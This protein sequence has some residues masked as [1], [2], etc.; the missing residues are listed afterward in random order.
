MNAVQ[1]DSGTT[2]NDVKVTA[3]VVPEHYRLGFLPRHFGRYFG[4]L[5]SA[6]YGHL[7]NLCPSYAGGFWQFLDLSNGGCFMAPSGGAYAIFAPNGFQ[8]TVD[9]EVVGI[10]ATLYALSHLSFEHEAAE[11][12]AERFHQLREF[13]LEHPQAGIIL[14]A[15]D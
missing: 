5:E 4:L 9:G 7:G 10:I 11:V 15:I 14:G 6:V 3:A 2:G 13:A 1:S 12:F 8:A